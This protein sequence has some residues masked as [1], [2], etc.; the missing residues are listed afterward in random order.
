MAADSKDK[1]VTDNG[2]RVV[3]RDR[4]K[5]PVY[6]R[7]W[8]WAVVI[9]VLLMISAGAGDDTQTSNTTPAPTTTEAAPAT[10][11]EAKWDANAVYD[12]LQTGMTKAEAEKII[13]KEADYC[14]T[15]ESEYF[16]KSEMCHYGNSFTDKATIT[17]SYDNDGK[18]SNKHKATF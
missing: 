13:A 8:F 9:F 16:G 18:L 7:V 3:Y 6:K 12:Q 14:T 10:Q 2:E 5:K 15:S 1:V 17:V 4:P 11:P